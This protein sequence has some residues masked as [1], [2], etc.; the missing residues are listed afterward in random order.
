MESAAEGV[1]A[2][3]EEEAPAEPAAAAAE[4]FATCP[5]RKQ[6]DIRVCM[7]MVGMSVCESP[8]VYWLQVVLS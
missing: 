5:C 1:A 3:D 7:L 8:H 4:P 2:A 6:C